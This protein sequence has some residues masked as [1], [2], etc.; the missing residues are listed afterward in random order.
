MESMSEVF[1]WERLGMGE[2]DH[3]GG[4]RP[5]KVAC[6]SR[7]GPQRAGD[8]SNHE[9]HESRIA[10]YQ[11]RAAKREPLFDRDRR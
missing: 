3:A 8:S 6:P 11:E 10:L 2:N 5:R 1:D 4:F 7:P 9:G